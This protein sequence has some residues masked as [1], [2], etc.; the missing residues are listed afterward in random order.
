VV[1]AVAVGGKRRPRY[2]ALLAD[3]EAGAIDVVIAW[4]P[5][6]LH[7]SPLELETYIDLSDQFG[8]QTHTVQAGA[9]DLSTP[10]GRFTTE[11]V[12]AERIYRLP[13]ALAV[14]TPSARFH[15]SS[16]PARRL[17]FCVIT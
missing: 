11:G 15:R 9:W 4:R 16:T 14:G 2:E 8:I 5:D 12:A 7:R 17:R 13:P 6:R 3:I 10:S 1:N